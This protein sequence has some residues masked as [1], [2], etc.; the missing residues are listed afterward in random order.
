[1]D[2]PYGF[3]KPVAKTLHDIARAAGTS[4]G[5]VGGL[6]EQRRVAIALTP[7]G[8]IPA[9]SGD[10]PGTAT[11][12]LCQIDGT[13]GIVT[14]SVTETGYNIATADVTEDEYVIVNREYISGQWVVTGL[15]SECAITDLRLN[16]NEL[17]YYKCGA[18]TTWHTGTECP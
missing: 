2:I 9:R 10:T 11:I 6:P 3:E 4:G 12:T 14:T 17:Q 18:W 8:G 16:G 13:N 5:G 15:V 7:S 1:M